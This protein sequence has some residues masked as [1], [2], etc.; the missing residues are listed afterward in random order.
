[1]ARCDADGYYYITDR[2]KNMFISGGENIYPAEIERVLYAHEAVAEAAVIG[3]PDTQWGEVGKA[4]IALKA[5][6]VLDVEEIRSYCRQRLAAYKVPKYVEFIEA[7][8]KN[9]AG[10]INRKMLH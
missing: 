10:K 8:P 6:S 1:M 9:D 5:A 3:I 2:K 4:Y 7:L